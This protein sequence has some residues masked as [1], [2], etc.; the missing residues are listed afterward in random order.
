MRIDISFDDCHVSDLKAAKLLN[1][2]GFTA[3]FYMPSLQVK[4]TQILTLKEVKEGLIDQGMEIGGHTVSH[5]P[6][7]KL[8]SDEKLKFEI[9]GNKVLCNQLMKRD[10]KKFCY[11]RGRHDERVREV[12]KK[13]NY[14]EAR[15][16]R[17][18]HTKND[19]GDPLQIPTTIHMFPREEYFGQDW[20]E[21]G[22]KIYA[23][24]NSETEFFSIWG[25]TV[26]LDRNNEWDKFEEMLIFMKLNGS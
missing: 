9:E 2:H 14:L 20:L 5:P 25:H 4:G 8:C 6:D 18:L 3:T 1:K 10:I 13:A 17:V 19:T 12:V 21:L 23:A 26:E 24:R 15:T 16:T 11:P 22:K 7:L